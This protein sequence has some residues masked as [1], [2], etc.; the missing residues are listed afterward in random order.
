MLL[1]VT[2]LRMVEAAVVNFELTGNAGTGLLTGNENPP[3]MTGGSGGLGAGGITYDTDTNI[4]SIDIL[5]GSVNGFTDLTGDVTVSHIHGFTADPPPAGW[6]QNAGVL[7]PL[8]TLPGFNS[9]ASAGGFNGSV[10]ISEAD[11]AGLLAGLTYI[12]VHTSSNPPGEIRGQLT[13]AAVVPVPA[14][15]YLFTSGLLGLVGLSWRRRAG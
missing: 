11:E 14:A 12:N 2:P 9:S 5:W 10:S 13:V 7:Y 1:L 3:V 4:L 15:F 6:S 8:H